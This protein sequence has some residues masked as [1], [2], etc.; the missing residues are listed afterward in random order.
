M[1]AFPP[2][3]HAP[4]IRKK[5]V[6]NDSL[7]RHERVRRAPVVSP[8]GPSTNVRMGPWVYLHLHASFSA[9][10]GS[11]GDSRGREECTEVG[12]GLRR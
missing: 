2:H 8:P 10:K 6:E 12:E 3:T 7:L 5:G 9:N 11:F 4:N 1:Y